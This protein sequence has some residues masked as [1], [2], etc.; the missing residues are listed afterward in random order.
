MHADDRQARRRR[1]A[2]VLAICVTISWF[3]IRTYVAFVQRK[4]LMTLESCVWDVMRATKDDGRRQSKRN[5]EIQEACA[6]FAPGGRLSVQASSDQFIVLED[7]KGGVLVAW[8]IPGN[9]S[10]GSASVGLEFDWSFPK[11]RR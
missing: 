8:H 11:G 10:M 3:G 4:K 7:D 5:D 6:Q 2:I 1:L 9:T